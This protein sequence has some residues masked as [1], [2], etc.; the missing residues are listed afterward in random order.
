MLK[1][2]AAPINSVSF[3]ERPSS[4]R[5]SRSITYRTHPELTLPR[6]KK[7]RQHRETKFK[8]ASPRTTS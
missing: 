1:E 3:P 4:A 6:S 5:R 8:A 7:I 2:A